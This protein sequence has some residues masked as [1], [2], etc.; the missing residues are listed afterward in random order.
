MHY[1][2]CAWNHL[3]FCV[4]VNAQLCVCVL[5]NDNA[6]YTYLGEN[7]YDYFAAILCRLALRV[8]T[9][10][11]TTG[12]GMLH[13]IRYGTENLHFIPKGGC[14]EECYLQLSNPLQSTFATVHSTARPVC[15]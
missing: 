4:T 7:Y 2:V 15:A 9:P 6:L 13:H 10:I 1:I 3:V 12:R 8:A 5:C 11:R 14:V